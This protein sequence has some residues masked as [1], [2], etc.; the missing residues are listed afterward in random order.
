[1][2]SSQQ[3]LV[4]LHVTPVSP[5][6]A[7]AIDCG[8]WDKLD[9]GDAT[10][11]PVKHRPGGSKTE[12]I[13]PS[14]PMFGTIT[15]ERVYDNEFRDDQNM[16]GK[17]RSLAGMAQA[18]VTEQPLD[19]NMSAFGTPR[20]FHGLLTSVKDGGVDSNS[21]TARLWQVDIDVTTSA[22]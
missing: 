16:I 8:I 2:S 14:L 11:T 10:A 7:A 21:E 17:L 6:G 19:A 15:L 18:T 20:T 22:H 4:H 12:V 5:K 13:Y 9:G 3:F 1:M